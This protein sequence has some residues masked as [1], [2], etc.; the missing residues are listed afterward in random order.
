M[1]NRTSEELEAILEQLND[2][3][4]A[5]LVPAM[6]YCI[7][8]M[9]LGTVGN[10]MV[11]YFYGFHAK[12]TSAT[13]FILALAV[14]D[15]IACV[16]GIP[17]EIADLRLFYLFDNVPACRLLC[18]VNH[19]AVIGSAFTLCFIA[20]DRYKRIC[21]PFERQM[22]VRRA[23]LICGVCVLLGVLLGWPSIALYT[24]EKV[25]INT[26]YKGDPITITG[27]DCTSVKDE[28]YDPYNMVF[29]AIQLLGF[30]GIATALIVC[31]FLVGHQLYKH[32]KFRFYVAQ[33]GLRRTAS[34]NVTTITTYNTDYESSETAVGTIPI[35]SIPE[36]DEDEDEEDFEVV[37]YEGPDDDPPM[38]QESIP[39][40]RELLE[41]DAKGLPDV[42]NDRPTSALRDILGNSRPLSQIGRPSSIIT[43]A[44]RRSGGSI[45]TV[46]SVVIC[47]ASENE[48][49][50]IEPRDKSQP[51][52]WRPRSAMSNDSMWSNSITR[53]GS[54]NSINTFSRPPSVTSIN[55]I[56]EN[57]DHLKRDNER[58]QKKIDV[59][60]DTKPNIASKLKRTRSDGC[61]DSK[62]LGRTSSSRSVSSVKKSGLRRTA[63]EDNAGI[64]RSG[65]T[66]SSSP[67]KGLKR[68]S[69]SESNKLN[70]DTDN[71]KDMRMKLLDINT[72][73]Y[74]VIM[75]V[76]AVV[77]ILSC[78]PYLGLAIWRVY[79]HEDLVYEFT[80]FKLVW[81]Q[82]GLRSYFLNCAI[83]P[84]IYGF[85]NS[86]F[87]AHFRKLWCSCC[88]KSNTTHEET[89]DP[90]VNKRA[91]RDSFK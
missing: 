39:D 57:N 8:L 41:L 36:E 86:Q 7:L 31:Y 10:C 74:T 46:K 63:S 45:M 34:G 68:T 76:I 19:F 13:C 4:A 40:L 69:S 60:N 38:M 27:Y 79:A 54:T 73:K 32:K 2:E 9:A 11:V 29:S 6:L 21:K 35:T 26:T 84:F 15:L 89:S 43:N 30:I 82:I 91:R 61:V 44:S 53:H 22:T 71:L 51:P 56:T 24:V 90:H 17:I 23:R 77:F 55:G 64:R 1:V 12:T 58:L 59:D 25:Q 33:K 3:K 42:D 50:S 75:I 20:I 83:N 78:V 52:T 88:C 47:D 67:R 62:R 16:F 49:F 85:F 70:T 18:F 87:R 5:V 14:F 48:V 65:S 80:D 66:G 72:V 28:A 81:F 37:E